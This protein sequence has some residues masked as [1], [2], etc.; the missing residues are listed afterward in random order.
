MT[1]FTPGRLSRI[2]CGAAR[3]RSGLTMR[4][5]VALP[6]GPTSVAYLVPAGTGAANPGSG[7]LRCLSSR[8]DCN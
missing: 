7:G 6:T 1:L 3:T 2:W 4:P 8:Y 5:V